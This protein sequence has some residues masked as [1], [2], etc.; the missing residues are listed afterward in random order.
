MARRAHQRTQQPQQFAANPYWVARGLRFLTTKDHARDF[1]TGMNGVPIAPSG[2]QD[3]VVTTR[4]IGSDFAPTGGYA[5]VIYD[6]Q[7]FNN[8]DI[9]ALSFGAS[10]EGWMLSQSG[11]AGEVWFANNVDEQQDP[12]ANQLCLGLLEAGVSRSSIKVP[13]ATDGTL[14]CFVVRKS[15]GA[16]A[17]WKNGVPQTVVTTGSLS[18][19]PTTATDTLAVGGK[20]GEGGLGSRV[21]V[22]TAV[23]GKA[24]TD[25]ECASLSRNPWQ[26]FS[27]VPHH[28][29][30]P[31]AAAGGFFARPY[32]DM[33]GQSRM[34]S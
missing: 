10:A 2:T 16:G 13:G 18:A 6:R 24:L 21:T 17:A 22:A 12:V 1:A 34:G 4:G 14:S 23:F 30:A 28:R 27:P 26:L 11:P 31:S 7:V 19:S 25:A 32:Y 3:R 9:T 15:N 29:W 5:V 8:G 33:I 20:V